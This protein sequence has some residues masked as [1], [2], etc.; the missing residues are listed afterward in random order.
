MYG[1][2]L[3]IFASAT[4]EVS[5]GYTIPDGGIILWSGISSAISADFSIYSSA[6]ETLIRGVSASSISI[7]KSGNLTHI[8]TMPT[9]G[10]EAAHAH[11]ANS[12]SG[13]PSS[14]Q[15]WGETGGTSTAKSSHAHNMTTV[16]TDSQGSHSHTIASATA[17]SNLPS[18]HRLYYIKNSSSTSS[19]PIGSILMFGATGSAV[20]LGGGWQ[21]CNGTNTTPDLR[22]K[23]I[24]AA[25]IDGDVDVTGGVVSHVHSTP[26]TTSSDGTHSHTVTAGNIDNNSSSGTSSESSPPSPTTTISARSHTHYRGSIATGSD[27]NHTHTV[28]NTN[29]TSVVP[30]YINLFYVMRIS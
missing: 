21:L 15:S 2:L 7:I 8:H 3:G 28:S 29:S 12:T 30:P 6:E 4:N 24:Y 20:S 10:T 25:K 27:S 23:F 18:Y 14:T 13:G 11:D 9:T 26:S 5:D 19:L 1:L 22:G 16:D 17:A